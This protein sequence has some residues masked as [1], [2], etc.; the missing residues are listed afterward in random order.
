M[1]TRRTAVFGGMVLI[2]VVAASV[3]GWAQPAGPIKIAF[4]A[5]LSGPFTS[6]GVQVRDGMKFAIA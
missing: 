1:R 2:A 4:L 5:S 3:V 6:W